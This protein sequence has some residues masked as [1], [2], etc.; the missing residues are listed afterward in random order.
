VVPPVVAEL[1][2]M[3]CARFGTINLNVQRCA[4]FVFVELG[5][6]VDAQGAQVAAIHRQWVPVEPLISD[7]LNIAH[8]CNII[9]NKHHMTQLSSWLPQM[10]LHLG[11]HHGT[12]DGAQHV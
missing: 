10:D 12:K 3:V 6:T 7:I 9:Y 5:C 2:A 8:A 1:L 11:D 4:D